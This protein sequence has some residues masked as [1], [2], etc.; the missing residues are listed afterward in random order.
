M[1]QNKVTQPSTDFGCLVGEVSTFPSA[2]GGIGT[3]SEEFLTPPTQIP[4]DLNDLVV[5][6]L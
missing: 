2:L 1:L 3:L 4:E 5:E 6:Q